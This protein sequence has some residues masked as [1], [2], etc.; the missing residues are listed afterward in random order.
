VSLPSQSFGEKSA[1]PSART[2]DEN[3]LLGIH[4]C[5]SFAALP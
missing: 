2:S 1:K 5:F 4:D 3:H